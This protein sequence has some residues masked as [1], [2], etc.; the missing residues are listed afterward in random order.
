MS[1]HFNHVKI[2][3]ADNGVLSVTCHR[4]HNIRLAVKCEQCP[5]YVSIDPV[6]AE[7]VCKEW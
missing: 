7:I 2:F 1:V 6:K 3:K 5:R 4:T